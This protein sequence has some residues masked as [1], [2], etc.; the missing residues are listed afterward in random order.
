MFIEGATHSSYSGKSKA[1]ALDK[2]DPTAT[3]PV[4]IEKITNEVIVRFLD[5]VVRGD[6]ISKEWLGSPAEIKA[7]S[8]DKAKIESK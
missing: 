7:L 2:P 1:L 6:V 8:Q 3:D 5:A 4:L